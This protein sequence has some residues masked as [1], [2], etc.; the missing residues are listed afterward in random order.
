MDGLKSQRPR[1]RRL[2]WSIG[3]K[4]ERVSRGG[5]HIAVSGRVD[6]GTWEYVTVSYE[7]PKVDELPTVLGVN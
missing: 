2:T 7:S 5:Y 1:G 3:N 4:G 6:A